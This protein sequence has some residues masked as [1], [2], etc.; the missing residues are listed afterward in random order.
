MVSKI[1]GGFDYLHGVE[2]SRVLS[3]NEVKETPPV[4]CTTFSIRWLT[5]LLLSSILLMHLRSR[6]IAKLIFFQED[7]Q[8]LEVAVNDN[9]YVKLELE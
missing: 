8:K 1:A 9:S 3:I 2:E 4:S 6:T 5:Q 7:G